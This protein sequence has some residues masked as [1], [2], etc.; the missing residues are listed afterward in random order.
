MCCS[1]KSVLSVLVQNLLDWSK[2][3]SLFNELEVHLARQA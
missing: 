1:A 3:F 2:I